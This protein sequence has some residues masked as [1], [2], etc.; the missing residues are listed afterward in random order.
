MALVTIADLIARGRFTAG[1]FEWAER[2]DNATLSDRVQAWIA[3][4]SRYIK[5]AV[6]ATTYATTDADTKGTLADA[7]LSYGMYI[8]LRQRL[9]ILSSRPEEGP[10]DVYIDLPQL[11]AEVETLKDEVD[12]LLAPY[13]A[14]FARVPGTAFAFG[15][16]V[17][18][19]GSSARYDHTVEVL[20]GLATDRDATD[21]S[22]I[23]PMTGGSD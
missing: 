20:E 10:P 7:E 8:G 4:A 11:R 16:T 3:Q 22:G 6:G 12:E 19:E 18:D 1:E 17:V 2:T 9:I 21:Y 23:E 15:G 14:S 13:R 5:Q